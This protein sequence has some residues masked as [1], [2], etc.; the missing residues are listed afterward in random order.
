MSD[1]WHGGKGDKSRVSDSKKYQHGMERI[2]GRKSWQ[3]WAVWDGFDLKNI[4]FDE[5]G[6]EDLEKISYKE[7]MKRVKR[8]N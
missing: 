5:S 8:L 4:Q 3:F 7:F 6:L 2:Y 1:K